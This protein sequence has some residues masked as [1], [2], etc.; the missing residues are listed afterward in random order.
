MSLVD[1]GPEVFPLEH[2]LEGHPAVEAHDLGEIHF[3]K[4]ISIVEDFGGVAIED[5]EGLIGVG[6]G[7]GEDVFAGEGRPGGGAA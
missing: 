5:A 2:L 4:P 3:A 1:A 7:V 6:F